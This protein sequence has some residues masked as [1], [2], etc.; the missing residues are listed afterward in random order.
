M[1]MWKVDR[2]WVRKLLK[3][4]SNRIGMVQSGMEKMQ[5]GPCLGVLT[6]NS[7]SNDLSD[8]I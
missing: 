8:Q 3:D 4:Y 1:W 7:N 2:F 5:L 6:V